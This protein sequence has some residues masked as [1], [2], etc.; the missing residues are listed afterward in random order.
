VK[1]T[2][3]LRDISHVVLPSHLR[4]RISVVSQN[5][6]KRKR[7]EMEDLEASRILIDIQPPEREKV[8]MEEVS[9]TPS[10]LA[11]GS[12]YEQSPQVTDVASTRISGAMIIDPHVRKLAESSN[13]KITEHAVWLLVVA[14]REFS[15]SLLNKT[16]STSHAVDA[17]RV[18]PRL[19]RSFALPQNAW[20]AEEK[21]DLPNSSPSISPLKCITS[22]DIH[23]VIANLPTS[24]RTL[25]GSVSRPVFERSLHSSFCGTLVMG[26]SAFDDVK[27]YIVSM[28]TPSESKRSTP[29]AETSVPPSIIPPIQVTH[30]GS[31]T[32]E[33]LLKGRKS[34]LTRGLGRGAKDLAALKARATS[35]T[36]K[37]EID[38]PNITDPE[39]KASIPASVLTKAEATEWMGATKPTPHH[40]SSTIPENSAE[41]LDTEI[42]P[43][44]QIPT[45]N[46]TPF[47]GQN[48]RQTSESS[49]ASVADHASNSSEAKSI[50]T[51]S[52]K[53]KGHG[54][55]NL[56]A[57]R[58][59][60]AT[61][62]SDLAA[63]MCLAA[64]EAALSEDAN[65]EVNEEGA[66]SSP[67]CSKAITIHPTKEV[68]FQA[69]NTKDGESIVESSD[70]V[71]HHV[72]NV[73]S[74]TKAST[75]S[76]PIVEREST[77][78]KDESSNTY[79]I[80]PVV[81]PTSDD[82]NAAT[83]LESPTL[84]MAVDTT[85]EKFAQTSTATTVSTANCNDA[86]SNDN[87]LE[88]S[89]IVN[90]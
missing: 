50:G 14:V 53:G 9:Y 82:A 35:I 90:Q 4:Q 88:Q 79:C 66:Q 22:S 19:T 11:V 51:S 78:P 34:P 62:S 49:V 76:L 10:V 85:S 40:P 27:Q 73:E 61:S 48:L 38:G 2:T 28:V 41:I 89:D 71:S 32:A 26:G 3:P 43:S 15:T 83:A 46:E 80:V 60:S 84:A 5:S 25:S 74:T 68:E 65:E 44:H 12:S 8:R 31:N 42:E 63:D 30:S 81:E 67:I 64:A 29:H 18:P 21:D 87:N 75:D 33:E 54:V 1:T 77:P 24:F 57:M 16:L 36:I 69:E 59:R 45:S 39:V 6:V 58:A 23:A 13:M 72:T 86:E 55:K 70:S 17:G 7:D 52:K 20:T 37:T 47:S 56:A